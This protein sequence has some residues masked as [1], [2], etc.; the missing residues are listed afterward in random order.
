MNTVKQIN[1]IDY[2]A[3]AF[4]K[5]FVKSF[6]TF[7]YN[8]IFLHLNNSRKENKWRKIMGF[9]SLLPPFFLFYILTSHSHEEITDHFFLII[10]SYRKCLNMN[11][12]VNSKV[13]CFYK[14]IIIF[15]LLRSLDYVKNHSYDNFSHD[16]SIC[17][18][19]QH[20]SLK[21]FFESPIAMV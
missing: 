19:D 21:L 1:V 6:K 20:N 12:N 16:N 14:E 18:G 3:Y 10:E 15:Q 7:S 11:L 5:S 17:F 13:K 9:Q 8:T 4:K 2:Q